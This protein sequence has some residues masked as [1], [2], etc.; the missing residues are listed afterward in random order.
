MS[1]PTLSPATP[2]VTEHPDLVVLNPPRRG[3]GAELCAWIEDAP[4]GRAI[5]SSCHLD[6]LV[7]DLRRMP[8]WT[9]RTGRLV[10][11]FPHTAHQEVIVELVRS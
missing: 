3:I 8:S 1:A 4:V 10:D 9:V 5:Y 2:P 7:V 11:M 6:S